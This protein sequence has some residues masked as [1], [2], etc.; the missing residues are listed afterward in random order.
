MR[1]FRLLLVLAALLWTGAALA[2]GTTLA[3][4]LS[5]TG[6]VPGV[7]Y[8]KPTTQWTPD[9]AAIAEYW[10]QKTDVCGREAA[11]LYGVVTTLQ[12][13]VADLKASK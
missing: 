8:F 12:A 5:T 9:V 1:N 10:H 13:Q 2:Q 11:N 3:V 6:I 4:P 7:N